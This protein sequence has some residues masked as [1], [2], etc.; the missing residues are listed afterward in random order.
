MSE[1]FTSIISKDN[2]M[3]YSAVY[4]LDLAILGC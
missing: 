1:Q 4:S 2:I 3:V